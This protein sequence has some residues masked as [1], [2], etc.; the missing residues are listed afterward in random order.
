MTSRMNVL[1]VEDEAPA[2][3]KLERYLSKYSEDIHILNRT[4]SIRDTSEWLKENQSSLDLIFMDIQLT[5]GLSFEI[6]NR[7]KVVK[8]VI[9]TTAFDEYAIDAFKVNSIAYLLKPIT[10][11]D[12]SSAL[13]KL[14]QM[15]IQLGDNT[16]S[17]VVSELSQRQYKSRFMVKVGEHIRS[18]Q[19]SEIS[20]FYSE[21]RTVYLVNN[22]QRKFIIDYKMEE[23]E[24]MLDPKE[25]YRLNRSFIININA[26]EEVLIYSNSRLKVQ[27]KII[28]DKEMIVS[29]EKVS[30]FKDWLSGGK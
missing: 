14:D 28:F 29:R 22:D 7:I 21:G 19:I 5:D 8:P 6:F 20:L 13:Q 27:S 17:N 15:K 2:A 30:D 3:E 4:T 10:F 16:L 11:M 1:I 24:E 12:L 23:L 9:F 26:I 18:I 25:F